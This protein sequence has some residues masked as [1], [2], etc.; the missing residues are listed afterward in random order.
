MDQG[1]NYGSLNALVH[2]MT[3]CSV[4]TFAEVESLLANHLSEMGQGLVWSDRVGFWNNIYVEFETHEVYICNPFF[5]K[6]S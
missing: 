2:K 4:D 1:V 5:K 3:M 6:T